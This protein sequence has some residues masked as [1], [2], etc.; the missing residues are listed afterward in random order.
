MGGAF[1]GKESQANPYA[2]AAALAA[3]KTNDPRVRLRRHEDMILTGKRHG[4]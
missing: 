3:Y 2:A 4:F 1:G